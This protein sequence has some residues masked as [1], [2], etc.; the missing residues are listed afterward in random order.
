MTDEVKQNLFDR[1]FSTKGGRGTGLGLLVT[2]KIIHEHGGEI[3]VE[4]KAG[5]GTTFSVRL[6]RIE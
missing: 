2:Q 5:E 1:F 4:S 3:S 6:G